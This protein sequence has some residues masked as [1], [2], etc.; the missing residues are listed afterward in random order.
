MK[1]NAME[2]FFGRLLVAEERTNEAR[3]MLI[4]IELNMSCVI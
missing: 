2:R 1:S 3:G 4:L